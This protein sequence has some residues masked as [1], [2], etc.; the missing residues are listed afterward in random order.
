[1]R[2]ALLVAGLLVIVAPWGLVEPKKDTGPQIQ[3]EATKV[4]AEAEAV[5]CR[6]QRKD[7]RES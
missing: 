4:I 1:M 3:F 5:T 6:T 7:S 2:R